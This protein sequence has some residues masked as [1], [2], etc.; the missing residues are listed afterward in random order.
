MRLEMEV[1]E[2]EERR[3]FFVDDEKKIGSFFSQLPAEE[4]GKGEKTPKPP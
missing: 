1:G 2:K 3:M 4:K